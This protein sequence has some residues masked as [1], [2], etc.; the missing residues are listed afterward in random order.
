MTDHPTHNQLTDGSGRPVRYLRVSVTDRCN[1]RCRYCAPSEDF[2]SL[3]HNRIISYEEIER[4]ARILSPMG[5]SSIRI[6]GGEPLVR[7]HLDR[8][9]SSLSKVPG[10]NDISL[11]T[12]GIL[13]SEL[14]KPLKDAGLSRVN[15]SLDTLREDR[16][17]WITSPNGNGIQMG[18][19][20]V[21]EGLMAAEFAGLLPVKINVVLMRGFNDDELEGF[22]ALTSDRDFEVRFIEFMPMSPEG[23]W[24]PEK[25]V[26]AAEAIGRLETVHGPLAQLGRCNGSGPAV[27]YQ[28][29][30][31]QGTVG[32]IT[33]ISQHFCLDCNRIRITADGKIRTCL[34]S[35][36]ETDILE[37]LRSGASDAEVLNVIQDA[38][39]RKPEGHGMGKGEGLRGCARTM[40]HIGG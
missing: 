19:H 30:G 26:P 27:C 16:F 34:F 17:T 37:P 22:A 18:P 29:P 3:S 21:M 15:V 11:T 24:G 28:I 12:N 39:N 36:N 4:L 10:I 7:K 1:L 25:V 38:L 33:P 20:R 40:S 13:L 23:F 32:F 14:A 31:Y 9:V 2:V 6:T 35:D 5:V 8:L